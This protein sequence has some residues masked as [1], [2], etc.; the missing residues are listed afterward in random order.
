MPPSPLDRLETPSLRLTRPSWAELT[1]YARMAADP[2]VMNTL[3][4][5]RSLEESRAILGRHID[6][7][8]RF[9]FGYYTARDR[10]GGRFAGRGGL[11]HVHIE[12][13]DEVEIGY[14]FL[15][16]YWGRGLA[17]ELAIACA[18]V[19]FEVLG[20][21]DLV[22]FTLPTNRASRRVM[23]KVGFRFERDATYA[24]LPHVLYRLTADDW[25]ATRPGPSA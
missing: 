13:R 14:G 17:T 2:A 4:G 1:D 15:A 10:A 3:G 16:T 7:W 12:G 24:G 19:G 21:P 11:R 18:R 25:R 23:E 22:C 20:R 6:H 5:V 8:C 9:G